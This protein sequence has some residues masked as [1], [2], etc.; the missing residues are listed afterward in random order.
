MTK[1]GDFFDN[2]RL[3]PTYKIYGSCNNDFEACRVCDYFD[4]F[5]F[6]IFQNLRELLR[7]EN[8][9]GKILISSLRFFLLSLIP[10]KRIQR[11]ETL[12]DLF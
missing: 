8:Q 3:S 4:F 1:P 11:K 6:N 5:D 9:K 12:K 2:Q 10:L 7:K